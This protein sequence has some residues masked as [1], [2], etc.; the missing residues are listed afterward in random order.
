MSSY[1]DTSFLV[2]L[3]GRDVN[4]QSAIA[5]VKKLRPH[6]MVTPFGETEFTNV[7]FA[8]PV[9]PKGWSVSEASAIEENFV[10]DLKAGVWQSEDLP[11]EV[12]A[13]ARELA[14]RHSP[15]LGCRVL[16]TLHV[17]SALV[18]QVQEFYTFDRD[19]ATLARA[20]GLQVNGC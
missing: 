6:F 19:Q 20:A 14:R 8:V 11:P 1:A 12:W 15:R 3:Y 4:S 17:A 13:R 18:L 7:V 10:Q 2:S 16:D 5:M 9:R